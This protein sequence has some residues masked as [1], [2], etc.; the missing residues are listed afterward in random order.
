MAG[1]VRTTQEESDR[2]MR[3]TRITEQDLEGFTTRLA[4]QNNEGMRLVSP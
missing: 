3:E 1:H 4:K 2:T